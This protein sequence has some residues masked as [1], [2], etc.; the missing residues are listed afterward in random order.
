MEQVEPSEDEAMLAV[1]GLSFWAMLL[2]DH[3]LKHHAEPVRDQKF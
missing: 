2:T 3:G 1:L